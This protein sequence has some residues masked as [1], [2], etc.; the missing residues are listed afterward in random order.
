MADNYSVVK[1][2]SWNITAITHQ[3]SEIQKRGT[4]HRPDTRRHSKFVDPNSE[5][6]H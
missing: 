4:A 5:Q 2:D 6:G 1:E 3:A